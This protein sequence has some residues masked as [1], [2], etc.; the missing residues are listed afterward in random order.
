M[1]GVDGQMDEF[2]SKMLQEF[3][4]SGEDPDAMVERMM[5]H[6]LGREYLYQPMCDIAASYPPW[7]NER[8]AQL[9]AAD[10]ANYEAQ[11]RCFQRIVAVIFE[12]GEAS[13][14]VKAVMAIMN[15]MQQYGQPPRELVHQ[16]TANRCDGR[17]GLG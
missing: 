11:H 7:I 8:R 15:E 14:E 17:G 13:E 3:R 4:G 10:L 16:L 9:T 1:P 5:A 2:L 6:M 12:K